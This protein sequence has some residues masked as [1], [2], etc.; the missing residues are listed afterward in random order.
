MRK[1]NTSIN[2]K[3]F[4]ECNSP[5]AAYILGILWADCSIFGNSLRL[6]LVEKDLSSI[7]HL[8]ELSGKWESYKRARPNRQPQ[9]TI[10]TSNKELASLFMPRDI[11]KLLSIIPQN[12]IYAWW[13]GYFDGDG[14]IYIHKKR[15]LFQVTFSSYYLE[16]WTFAEKL[17]NSI[18]VPTAIARVVTNKNHSYS[19]LRITARSNIRKVYDFLYQGKEPIGFRRKWIKFPEAWT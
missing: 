8:F 14:N 17:F 12:L 4:T 10:Y 6:E 7:K 3:F 18:N 16:D 11:D 15:S 1:T 19:S 9:E 5:E 2:S 13:Q